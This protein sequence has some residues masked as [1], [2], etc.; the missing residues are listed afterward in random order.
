MGYQQLSSIV[1]IT[2]C[3]SPEER[4]EEREA[5]AGDG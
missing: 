1:D 4:E 5:P 2:E 3:Q